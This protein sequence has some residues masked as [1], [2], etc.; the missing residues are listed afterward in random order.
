M[1]NSLA[2]SR[3]EYWIALT[4]AL[5]A[6]VVVIFCTGCAG[7]RG[8]GCRERGRSDTASTRTTPGASSEVRV[9][10]ETRIIAPAARL[11]CSRLRTSGGFI[12]PIL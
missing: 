6:D 2:L 10:M 5:V 3:P 9:P 11:A 12:C 7:M 4:G 1:F 8:D